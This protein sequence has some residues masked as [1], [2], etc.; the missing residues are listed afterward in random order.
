MYQVKRRSL[1]DDGA[2]LTQYAGL[3]V[4]ACVILGAFYATGIT[5]QVGTGVRTALCKIFSG[6][7]GNCQE[8]EH[9]PPLP[10]QCTVMDAMNRLQVYADVKE[11]TVGAGSYDGV[12]T[13]VDPNTGKKSAEVSLGL[14]LEADAGGT[15]DS[16]AI[17]NALDKYAKRVPPRIRDLISNDAEA[18]GKL[19][20]TGGIHYLYDFDDPAEAQRFHDSQRG[21]DIDRY[22]STPGG[23]LPDKYNPIKGL[24]DRIRGK[25]RENRDPDG[26]EIDLD[27]Q[28]QAGY[29]KDAKQ[30]GGSASG[31]ITEGGKIILRPGQGYE[32]TRTYSGD[33]SADANLK[34]LAPLFGQSNLTP[35]AGFKG[36]F[37][38]TVKFDKDGNPAQF[39]LTTEHQEYNGLH[40]HGPHDTAQQTTRVLDLQDPQNAQAVYSAFPD[41]LATSAASGGL[42][43][44]PVQS[45]ISDEDGSLGN[46]LRHHSLEVQNTYDTNNPAPKN[47]A[48]FSVGR[49]KES[50]DRRLTKSQAIDHDAPD[51]KWQ[52]LYRCL[53]M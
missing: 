52:N 25:H 36:T 2:S 44:V 43:Q 46:R 8:S 34:K 33:F 9:K 37:S 50:S 11:F 23:I 49:K 42:V 26:V 45:L 24:A 10:Y 17:K 19:G 35:N 39:M 48:F 38:Y 30:Y 1:R 18:N 29:K 21:D 51:G 40:Q 5:G 28:A 16:K 4:L 32:I 13:M 3:I 12:T 41:L 27:G 31:K 20:V 53:G 7:Q 14:D 15:A 6:F 47:S 22:T